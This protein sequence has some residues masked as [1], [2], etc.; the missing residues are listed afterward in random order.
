MSKFTAKVINLYGDKACPES[1][2]YIINF[3]GGYI[4]L[5]RTTE[6]RYWAHVGVNK[7]AILT[8]IA[9]L[10]KSGKIVESRIDYTYEGHIKHGIL[11]VPDFDKIQKIAVLIDTK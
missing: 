4:E 3:P 1:A 2:Q 9:K 8:D 5:S 10:S 11:D 7:G 6:G